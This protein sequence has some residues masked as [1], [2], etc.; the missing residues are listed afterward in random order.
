MSDNIQHLDLDDDEFFDAPKALRQYAA[1]LK[2]ALDK[3][4][5]ELTTVRNQLSAQ[6]LSEVLSD[7]GFKNPKRVERDLIS[8]GIDPL[9]KSAV[10]KWLADNGDDYARG[11]ANAEAETPEVSEDEQQAHEQLQ[12]GAG[13][14]A[15]AD[16]SKIDAALAEITPDMNGAQVAAVYAKHGV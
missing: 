16:M 9:D 11:S 3:A 10:D 1:S 8:D 2:K 15:P 5:G 13:F 4:N 12:A 6:A 14:R 7:K